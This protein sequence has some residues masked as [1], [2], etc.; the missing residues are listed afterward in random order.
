MQNDMPPARP[1]SCFDKP[2]IRSRI[3]AVR[4][5]RTPEHTPRYCAA[6]GA[7]LRPDSDSARKVAQHGLAVAG[8][9][10]LEHARGRIPDR[11]AQYAERRPRRA[12][13]A[14]GSDSV[15]GFRPGAKSRAERCP[16]LAKRAL[17][18]RFRGRSHPAPTR[19]RP[20]SDSSSPARPLS[21]RDRQRRSS[22]E[23]RSL[24]TY[25]YTVNNN[26]YQDGESLPSAVFAY[27]ISPMQVFVQEEKKS[28]ASF[29]TQIC[30]I[31]GGVFTVTGLLDGLVYHG[32]ASIK[33][34]MELGKAI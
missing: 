4:P 19:R 28:F 3:N 31:I 17:C 2:N 23:R 25:Q 8:N 33:R 24:D 21:T 6:S 30:A 34:K 14:S 20:S 12:K 11:R 1:W 16:N 5:G 26:D 10:V 7:L 32:S 29:L 13:R 18:E 15:A 22:G 27:D 9:G